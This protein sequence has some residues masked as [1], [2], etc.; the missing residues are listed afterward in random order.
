ML[1]LYIV[2]SDNVF[3]GPCLRWDIL[4]VIYG[5]ASHLQMSLGSSGSSG[6]RHAAG[7]VGL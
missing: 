6:L 7:R 1:Q 3:S 5:T 4:T 2:L